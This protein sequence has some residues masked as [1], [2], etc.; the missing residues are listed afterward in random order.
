MYSACKHNTR[1][2]IEAVHLLRVWPCTDQSEVTC[3]A[4]HSCAAGLELALHFDFVPLA[5]V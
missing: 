1:K 5:K 4:M 2:G 3:V